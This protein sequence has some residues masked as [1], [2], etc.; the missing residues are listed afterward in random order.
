MQP[1]NNQNIHNNR[2]CLS[3]PQN[4]PRL[5]TKQTNETLQKM[6]RKT[7]TILRHT[8]RHTT[9]KNKTHQKQK[10]KQKNIKTK[11]TTTMSKMQQTIRR[12]NN[13]HRTQLP[14]SNTKK[15]M[16]HMHI[17]WL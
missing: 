17:P 8:I 1:N 14:N 15:T 12:I 2:K 10:I 9:K 6:H 5:Q 16:L 4:T 7:T 11:T 3:R 13:N